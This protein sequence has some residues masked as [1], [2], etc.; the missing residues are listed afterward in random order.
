MFYFAKFIQAAGV[1]AVTYA[2]AI[3]LTQDALEQ[4]LKL[5]MIGAAIFY[6]GRM[7]ERWASA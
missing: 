5:G 1:V 3:G 2:L 6:V 4:E 7:V